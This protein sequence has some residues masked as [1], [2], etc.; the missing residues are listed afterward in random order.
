M[1]NSFDVAPTDGW[2]L[3]SGPDTV[4]TVG[5]K[6]S[7]AVLFRESDTLP[8]EESTIGLR[9]VEEH[10]P[11]GYEMLT[12]QSLYGKRIFGNCVISVTLT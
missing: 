6:G 11:L 8:T 10:P 9:M 12:G 4:G 7:G 2:D 3:L 1:A 5:V